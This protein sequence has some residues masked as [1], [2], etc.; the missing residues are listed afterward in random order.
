VELM[1]GKYEEAILSFRSATERIGDSAIADEAMLKLGRALAL[2]GKVNSAL[3]H[4]EELFQASPAGDF[5]DDALLTRGEI[6][7]GEKRYDEAATAFQRL[8]QLHRDRDV[9]DDALYRIGDCQYNQG[10]YAN[11]LDTYL[12]VVRSYPESDLWGQAVQGV[13][14]SALQVQD[15]DRAIAI[16]D[17]IGER[18]TGSALQEITR[19]KA[20]LLF[21][22]KRYNEALGLFQG[23]DDDP[24]S[25]MRVAWCY[26]RLGELKKAADVFHSV[27]RKWP[28]NPGAPE[29]LYQASQMNRREGRYGESVEL[30]NSILHD[31][32]GSDI[33]SAAKYDL[34]LS[35][36]EAGRSDQAERI[37]SDLVKNRDGEWSRRARIRLGEMA[38][39]EEDPDSALVW[40]TPVLSHED[41]TIGVE[42]HWIAA[43]AELARGN[44]EKARRLFIRLSYLFP[45]SEKAIEARHRAEE[46]ARD[47][48]G[49]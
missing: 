40:V 12:Q 28:N 4:L 11:A 15:S 1:A 27:A 43:E 13:L 47:S 46:L 17:S 2:A 45:E 21:G 30:L 44:H 19:A 31:Y 20:E 24:G 16:A 5:A 7:F 49:L 35:W 22:L 26:E 41:P 3:D 25:V 10:A 9:R 34:G 37:W 48:S 42:A 23:I 36:F 33:A 32:P 29:A 18:V 14:W 38:L 8:I 39:M 6:L